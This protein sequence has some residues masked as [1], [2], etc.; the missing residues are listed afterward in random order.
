[1]LT[2]RSRLAIAAAVAATLSA[3]AGV[4][5]ESDTFAT[6]QEARAAGAIE[7]GWVPAGLPETTTDLRDAHLPSGTH[8]GRFS[9]PPAQAD[10]LRALIGTEITSAPP[11]CDPPGRFEWW[12]RLL[13]TPINLE[14]AHVTGLHL[15]TSRDGRRAFAINWKQGQGYYWS[16]R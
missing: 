6:L 5:S 15:Y 4:R 16:T 14:T 12:P 1:M 3:C 7:R 11:P 9:F 2:V 10:A 8:W 13:R